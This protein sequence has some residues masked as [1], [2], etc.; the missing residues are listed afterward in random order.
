VSKIKIR[1]QNKY[2][3]YCKFQG[4]S[5]DSGPTPFG[6]LEYGPAPEATDVAEAWLDGKNRKLAGSS[7]FCPGDDAEAIDIENPATRKILAQL[8]NARAK[9][10]DEVINRAKEAFDGGSGGTLKAFILSEMI[11]WY[12]IMID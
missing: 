4:N 2:L 8:Q 6:V 1:N 7:G 3:V 5:T 11:H 10:V 9:S 12:L